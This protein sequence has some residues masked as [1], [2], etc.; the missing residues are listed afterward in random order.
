MGKLLLN[1]AILHIL[2]KIKKERKEKKT[3]QIINT[4]K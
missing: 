3:Q 4:T 1:N 2:K